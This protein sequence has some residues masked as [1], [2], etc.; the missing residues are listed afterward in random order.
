MENTSYSCKYQKYY[1]QHVNNIYVWLRYIHFGVLKGNN[2]VAFEYWKDDLWYSVVKKIFDNC[3]QIYDVL[4]CNCALFY[5]I[6]IM[7]L[8]TEKLLLI[9]WKLTI[10]KLSIASHIHKFAFYLLKGALIFSPCQ[11]LPMKGPAVVSCWMF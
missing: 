8:L 3:Q 1:A 10:L 2:I 6:Y 9:S 5:F 7:F 4:Y 11:Y